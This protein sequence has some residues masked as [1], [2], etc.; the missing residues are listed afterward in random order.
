[1]VWVSAKSEVEV[2]SETESGSDK[3]DEVLSLS[4]SFYKLKTYLLEMIEKYNI[5]LTKHKTLNK[6][7]NAL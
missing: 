2:S 3:E 7:A 6:K 5:F 1:M 4:L